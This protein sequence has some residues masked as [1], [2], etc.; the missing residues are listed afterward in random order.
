[1]GDGGLDID[2]ARRICEPSLRYGSHIISLSLDDGY[3][4]TFLDVFRALHLCQFAV[5][6][7]A[8]QEPRPT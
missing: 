5:Q 4:A 8:R 6:D 2:K 7:S 3:R 1:M